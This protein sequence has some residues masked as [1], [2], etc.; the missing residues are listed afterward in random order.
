MWIY[1]SG[2]MFEITLKREVTVFHIDKEL[3]GQ[4]KVSYC[5]QE[6]P[7]KCHGILWNLRSLMSS[8]C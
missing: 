6:C 8:L 4:N 5:G 1:F 3:G 7:K 2:V